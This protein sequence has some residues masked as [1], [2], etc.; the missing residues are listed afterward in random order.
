MSEN[1]EHLSVV[2]GTKERLKNVADK[3]KRT[4][5]GQLDFMLDEAEKQADDKDAK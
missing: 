2:K 4:M 5:R 3:N 1:E